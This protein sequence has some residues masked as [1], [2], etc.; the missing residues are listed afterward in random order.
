MLINT[1]LRV[2]NFGSYN[3]LR[4]YLLIKCLDHCACTCIG[5]DD[6]DFLDLLGDDSDEDKAREKPRKIIRIKSKLSIKGKSSVRSA[7]GSS[8]T[9]SGSKAF[10][11]QSTGL[12]S[13]AGT[14]ETVL[15][16]S[17]GVKDHSRKLDT[18]QAS[19][20]FDNSSLGGGKEG[21]QR[22]KREEK[23]SNEGGGGGGGRGGNENKGKE[24]KDQLTKDVSDF[25]DDDDILSGLGFEDNSTPDKSKLKSVKSGASDSK[26]AELMSTLQTPSKLPLGN[27]SARTKEREVVK[28]DFSVNK[29]SQMKEKVDGGGEGESKGGKR[30]EDSYQFGGYFPS[31]IAG[32]RPKGLP[33]S[34]TISQNLLNQKLPSTLP[35]SSLH[36][37]SQMTTPV[38]LSVPQKLEAKETTT[39]LEK[40]VRFSDNVQSV[41]IP[42][43][44]SESVSP[45]SSLS[46]SRMPTS[47][48]A[49]T[50]D[51]KHK[52]V[53]MTSREEEEKEH[54]FEE[55]EEEE[56][57]Q[58]KGE[59]LEENEEKEE[60][61]TLVKHEKLLTSNG[62]QEEKGG[63]VSRTIKQEKST[64]LVATMEA[65]YE[66]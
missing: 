3:I 60:E 13:Q 64:E 36:K 8:I 19:L 15:T 61:E 62:Y 24:E 20:K 22:E 53:L 10:Q 14:L 30:E 27:G 55:D 44:S 47:G 43:V 23:G 26:I 12:T 41:F 18:P 50:A 1:W 28:T 32:S 5:F 38:E 54:S 52:P 58:T 16:S 37:Q 6:D 33:N 34:S 59:K 49:L 2:C 9:G 56:K 45:I 4:C 17:N 31:M 66:L 35:D 25:G 29:D 40:S 11:N 51:K 65:R 39:S 63:P 21:S 7:S 42:Q 57:Q 46:S 48:N